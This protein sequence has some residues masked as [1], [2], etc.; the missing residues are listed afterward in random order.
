MKIRLPFLLGCIILSGC[1]ALGDNPVFTT[2]V[3]LGKTKLGGFGG[4][5]G[6]PAFDPHFHYLRLVVAGET[7]YLA[8]GNVDRGTEFWYSAAGEVLR[9]ENGRIAGIMGTPIEWR[10]V[11]LPEFPSWKIL[12][13]EKTYRWERRMD[14]M[15]GYR[16]GVADELVLHAIAPRTG[17]DLRDVDPSGLSWFEETSSR[18]PKAFYAVDLKSGEVIYAETCLSESF[19]FSWQ[20]LK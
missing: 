18:L 9:I 8:R 2:A 17:S 19:C 20:R 14:I 4:K 6:K 16:Y 10:N 13:K 12:E 11:V 3:Q 5:S 1:S 15:P 7:V